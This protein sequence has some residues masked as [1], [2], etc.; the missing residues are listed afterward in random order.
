MGPRKWGVPFLI[1]FRKR[2]VPKK[3]GS[4]RK[5]GGVPILEKTVNMCI[6]LPSLKIVKIYNTNS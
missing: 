4:L 2:E 6:Y 3:G 5:G 1:C